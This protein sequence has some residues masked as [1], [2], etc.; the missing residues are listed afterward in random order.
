MSYAASKV[1]I[2]TEK[3]LLEKV[4]ALIENCGASGYTVVAAGGKGSRGIRSTGRAAIV[5]EFSNIK[6]EVI[7]AERETAE[8]IADEVAAQFFDNYSGI[9]YFEP[10]EIIRPHKF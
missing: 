6:I 7:T 3:L 10:V 2:I 8:R 9:T 5:D 4:T 1:V